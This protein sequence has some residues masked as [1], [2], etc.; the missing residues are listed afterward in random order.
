MN[1]E[2]NMAKLSLGGKLAISLENLPTEL[3]HRIASY[4]DVADV[5]ALTCVSRAIR[6][7][8]SNPF[9]FQAQFCHHAPDPESK[10][11]PN[12]YT[13]AHIVN[14]ALISRPESDAGTIWSHLAAVASTLPNLS[15]ELDELMLPYRA[16]SWQS[17]GSVKLP[18][19]ELLR[20]TQALIGTFST[21]AV[22]GYIPSIDL[23]VAAATTGLLITLTDPHNWASYIHVL[24]QINRLVRQQAFVLALGLLQTQVLNNLGIMAYHLSKMA[25][26]DDTHTAFHRFKTSWEGRQTAALL[27]QVLLAHLLRSSFS[28]RP[29][30]EYLPSPRKLP[31]AMVHDEAGSAIV[32]LPDPLS[33]EQAER[34]LTAFSSTGSWDRWNRRY[35][36]HLTEEMEDGE[37][38]GYF[39]WDTARNQAPFLETGPIE[40]IRFR[41]GAKESADGT[42]E[43]IADNCKEPSGLFALHGEVDTLLQSIMLKKISPRGVECNYRGWFTPLGIAGTMNPSPW[44]LPGW[45]WIW[46][47]EW[48]EDTPCK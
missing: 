27:V 24:P 47:K 21:F 33:P 8:C 4:C 23:G 31:L 42:I 41:F 3:I 2:I 20:K 46:K 12:K 45:F 43:V 9:V 10:T 38:Y 39:T 44:G 18:S 5:H 17:A 16:V 36:R 48:M 13:L 26:W 7:S 30:S 22:L 29:A 40:N 32:P 1:N 15:D 11:I 14:S 19:S 6:M 35:V 25:T 28:A 34:R 37:W